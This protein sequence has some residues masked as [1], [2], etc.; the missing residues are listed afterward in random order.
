MGLMPFAKTLDLE[1][2]SASPERVK[3]PASPTPRRDAPQ[4]VRSWR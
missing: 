1:F 4:A 3:G 2:V